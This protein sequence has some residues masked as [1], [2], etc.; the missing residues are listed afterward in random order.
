MPDTEEVM[1]VKSSS[2]AS[3]ISSLFIPADITPTI[4]RLLLVTRLSHALQHQR[5]VHSFRHTSRLLLR[6]Y[7]SPD[8]PC[9]PPNSVLTLA[10][11][12]TGIECLE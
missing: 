2:T 6:A 3:N 9:V 11:T 10:E 8:A 1:L 12:K 5:L 4:E 7:C